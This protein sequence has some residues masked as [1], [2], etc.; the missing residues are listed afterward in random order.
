MGKRKA[1]N[2]SEIKKESV[3]KTREKKVKEVQKEEKKSIKKEAIKE[4]YSEKKSSN[5]VVYI[6]VA[7]LIAIVLFVIISIDKSSSKYKNKSGNMQYDKVSDPLTIGEEKYLEFLWI[8]DGAFND[9]RFKEK[10]KVNGKELSD[11]NKKFTCTYEK[12]SNT[13]LAANFEEAFANVFA[14]NIKYDDVYSDGLAIKWY[15][16][17]GDN[18]YFKNTNS[19]NGERM[20][21]EQ[22]LEFVEQDS[23]KLVFKVTYIDNIAAG[24]YKGRRKVVK[25]FILVKEDS[26]WK[27]STAHYH[28]PCYMDY[29]I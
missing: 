11:D 13:C 25:D 28:D 24:I 2:S 29:N 19:C 18:Y 9:S 14:S 1:N 12:G 5:K 17:R 4:E 15:E 21:T 27:V 8:V 6:I 7:V 26:D 22:T 10:I 3:R 16:K 23:D 20:S